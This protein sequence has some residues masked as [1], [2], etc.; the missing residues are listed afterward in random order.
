MVI[1]NNAFMT[2]KSGIAENKPFNSDQW[3]ICLVAYDH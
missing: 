1:Q 3:M 2:A